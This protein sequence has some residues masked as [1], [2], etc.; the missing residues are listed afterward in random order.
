MNAGFGDAPELI[1]LVGGNG[2]GKSTYFDLYLKNSGL[3]FVNADLIAKQMFGK[4]AEALSLKA[5]R[6]AEDTR[7]RLLQ[8]RESFC[9]E[10]VFS[11]PSKLDF[12]AQ[13]KAHGYQIKMIAIYTTS[14]ELNIARVAQRVQNGGHSVA[15]DKI[16]ERIP[17]ALD[18]IVQAVPLCDQFVLLDN[19]SCEE[20]FRLILALDQGEIVYREKNLPDFF[21]DNL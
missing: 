1:I 9:F 7:N 14:I 10:T 12:L 2:S 4:D 6:I 3:P 19:S 20:P 17:R 13:A 18:H 21:P 8:N 5:A 15:E 16:A 11:H